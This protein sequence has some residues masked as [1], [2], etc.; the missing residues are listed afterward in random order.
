[1]RAMQNE[2]NVCI[3]DTKCENCRE[4]LEVGD[5][6]V[7][8]VDASGHELTYCCYQCAEEDLGVIFHCDE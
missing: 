8:V 3:D 6:C 4:A 2:L 7:D 1:M 5:L